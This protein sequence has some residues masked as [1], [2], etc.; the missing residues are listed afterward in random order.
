MSATSFDVQALFDVRDRAA[1]IT[2]GSGHFGRAMALALPQAGVQVA[3]LGRHVETAQTVA[4]AIQAEGGT[5]L[6]IACDVLSRASSVKGQQA[7]FDI[8]R[9]IALLHQAI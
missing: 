9:Q 6:S 2:G 3:I 4:E 5:A 8:V 7:L 1:V